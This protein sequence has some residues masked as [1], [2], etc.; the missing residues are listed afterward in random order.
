MSSSNRQPKSQ[1]F[2]ES[3]TQP[4]R[5]VRSLYNERGER[6]REREREKERERERYVRMGKREKYASGGILVSLLTLVLIKH[7]LLK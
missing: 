3:S 7:E 5:S 4:R 2:V 1:V 6:E